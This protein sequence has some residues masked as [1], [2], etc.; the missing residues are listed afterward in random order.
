MVEDRHT[1]TVAATGQD[2]Y[3]R[4][5]EHLG[6]IKEIRG[7]YIKV[8]APMQPDYWLPASTLG[9]PLGN[10]GTVTFTKAELDTF[11]LDRPGPDDS[12]SPSGH[13][14]DTA[15]AEQRTVSGYEPT[16]VPYRTGFT[17]GLQDREWPE[18]ESEY[19]QE[20]ERGNTTGSRRWDEVAPGYRYAHEMSRD[21]KY[22]GRSWEEI[23]GELEA[24]YP[25]W[26]RQAG[27]PQEHQDWHRTRTV[28]GEAWLLIWRPR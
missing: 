4:D 18:A 27:L 22:Q 21:R 16:T 14:R 24:G 20:W 1:T 25:S 2:L 19:R 15:G 12:G 7:A 11:K 23:E 6:K 5:G 3:T 13:E 26:S 28:T 9:Q 8:D 17:A 10:D